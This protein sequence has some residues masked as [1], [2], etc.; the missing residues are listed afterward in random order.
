MIGHTNS[1]FFMYAKYWSIMG[2]VIKKLFK[3]GKE[4]IHLLNKRQYRD[5]VY[6]NIENCNVA[7]LKNFIR[8][9]HIYFIQ[10]FFR[11]IRS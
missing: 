11:L 9:F 10:F 8:Y 2:D 4:T 5:S 1:N 6:K 3:V 7:L